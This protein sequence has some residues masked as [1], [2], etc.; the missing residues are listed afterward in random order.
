[1]GQKYADNSPV[2][3]ANPS[4]QMLQASQPSNIESA[5]KAFIQDAAIDRVGIIGDNSTEPLDEKIDR[6][7][8]R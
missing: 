4:S 7:P 2:I 3:A 6:I 1:M 8:H 5:N